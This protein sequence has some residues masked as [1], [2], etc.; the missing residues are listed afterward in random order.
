[1]RIV[2]RGLTIELDP[3][4]PRVLEVERAVFGALLPVEKP[5][6]PEPEPVVISEKVRA[7]WKALPKHYRRELARLAEK[8]WKAKELEQALGLNQKELNGWHSGMGRHARK[9]GL[10]APVRARGRGRAG[11]FYALEETL[12]PQVRALLAEAGLV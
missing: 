7:L 4:D 9:H 6:E 5:P 10:P 12:A 1:M 11:R 3:T 2:H 8:D